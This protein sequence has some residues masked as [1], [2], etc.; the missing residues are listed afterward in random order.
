M[1]HRVTCGEI[2]IWQNIRK[3]RN[4][5]IM[6]VGSIYISSMSFIAERLAEGL[7]LFLLLLKLIKKHVGLTEKV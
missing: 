1:T 5:M 3:S 7:S 4:T 2:K 6:I